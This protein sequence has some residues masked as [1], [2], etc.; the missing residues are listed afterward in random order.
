MERRL[1]EKRNKILYNI[2]EMYKNE[3][4]MKELAEMLNI[5]LTTFWRAVVSVAK[6]KSIKSRKDD[7][8]SYIKR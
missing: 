8:Q 2:W 6:K 3:N 5:P 1:V 7:N 4:T